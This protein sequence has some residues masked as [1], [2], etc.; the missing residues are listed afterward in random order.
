MFFLISST[1]LQHWNKLWNK[2]KLCNKIVQS[3]LELSSSRKNSF[4]WEM[5][6]I[7]WK[8]RFKCL[9]Y[10]NRKI[11]N[12]YPD[13]SFRKIRTACYFFP[14]RHVRISVPHKRH[15]QILKLM[16]RK[17]RS[18][19]PL[20]FVLL[21]VLVVGIVDSDHSTGRNDTTS[22]TQFVFYFWWCSYT[23]KC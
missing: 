2:F 15:L 14:G 3:P 13:S 8:Q 11:N 16:L 10:F 5:F 6:A 23:W 1:I 22:G 4:K 19:S 21:P 17:M 18:L 7:V 12:S 20:S 9:Q